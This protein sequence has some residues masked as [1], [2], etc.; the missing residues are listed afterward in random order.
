M[1]SGRS[2][3]R[4]GFFFRNVLADYETCVLMSWLARFTLLTYAM[5]PKSYRRA[6][7]SLAYQYTHMYI[8]FLLSS[9]FDIY[10]TCV[11]PYDCW[12]N[13]LICEPIRFMTGAELV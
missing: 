2:P 12:Y 8:S 7:G 6:L 5:I 11:A 4:V 1:A 9:T 10:P 3:L 13:A